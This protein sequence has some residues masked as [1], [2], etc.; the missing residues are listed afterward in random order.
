MKT[1]TPRALAAAAATLA[2][3]LGACTD[4][5]TAAPTARAPGTRASLTTSGPTLIPNTV[6]YRDTGGKPA[7]GRSGSAELNAFALLDRDGVATLSLSAHHVTE[8]WRYGSITNAHIKALAPDGQHKFTRN[9]VGS[10]ASYGG[11]GPIP[12][13]LQIKGLGRGDQLQVQASVAGIDPHRVDVVTVTESVKRLPDLRVELSAPAEVESGTPVNILAVVSEANGDMG[14]SVWCELYVGGYFADFVPGAWVDAGDAVTCAMTYSFATPGTYPLEVRVSTPG[15]R[16]WDTGNN[17]DT[18]TIQ[19][20]G[21]SPRFYTSASFWQSIA[22][23]TTITYQSWIDHAAG[24]AREYSS[25]R[26]ET[27]T[28]QSATLY[29]HMPIQVDGPGRSAHL[30]VHRRARGDVG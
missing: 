4:V 2:L 8:P 26:A 18:A 22:V 23:N 3:A 29:G 25:E 1:R 30:H 6:K 14:A 9:L 24:T 10:G 27:S 7:K 12:G 5:P 20:N 17:T 13:E 15:L 28:R 21:E 19:V 16:E 11:R